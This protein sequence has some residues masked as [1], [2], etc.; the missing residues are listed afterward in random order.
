[1]NTYNFNIIFLN[2]AIA[3]ETAWNNCKISQEINSRDVFMKK[4]KKK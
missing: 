4:K 3:I 1:M 2:T